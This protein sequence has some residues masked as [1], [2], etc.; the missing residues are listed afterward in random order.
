MG[1]TTRLSVLARVRQ[2]A[3]VG[4]EEFANIYRPLVILRGKD[5]GLTESELDD[6]IQDVLVACFSGQTMFRYDPQKGSFRSYLR[7]VIDRRAL[8]ILR[9]R[10]SR[11]RSFSA[12]KEAGAIKTT[13]EQYHKMQER[14]DQAWRRHLLR[15]ALTVVR[16]QVSAS[17]ME[18]FEMSA[19]Q[20]RPARDVAAHIGISV[21]DVYVCK[22]RVLARLRTVVKMLGAG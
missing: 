9:K 5:R 10:A 4:W 2:G 1:H 16:E 15:E 11:E 12:L 22:H 17:T 18:A 8:D 13:D 6:L 21:E 19:F 7:K 14:W 20:G 3:D